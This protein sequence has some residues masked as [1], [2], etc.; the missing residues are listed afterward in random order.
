[1]G[2]Q[3]LN[4]MDC[5]GSIEFD[6][7]RKILKKGVDEPN[8]AEKVVEI[9]KITA[10]LPRYRAITV[11]GDRMNDAGLIVTRSWAIASPTGIRYCQ[12]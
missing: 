8:W 4:L 10:P 6:P 3:N 2:A 7:F 11:T 12:S 1:M 9:V 5:F